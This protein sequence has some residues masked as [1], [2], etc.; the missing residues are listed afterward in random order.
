MKL[1]SK[2]NRQLLKEDNKKYIKLTIFILGLIFFVLT[3]IKISIIFSIIIL[4]ISLL[5][6]YRWLNKAEM[7]HF[8]FDFIMIYWF[9]VN[10]SFFT[11]YHIKVD[12]YFIP[13]L[14][15]FAYLFTLSL[16]LIFDKLKS[17]RH[18]EKIK[19]VTP[20]AIVCFLLLC[21]GVYSLTSSPHTYDNQMHPNFFTA[22]SE[23]KAVGDW[24]IKHDPEYMNK[25]VWAD[26]GGDFTFLLKSRVPSMEK[27]SEQNNFTDRMIKENV[28]YFIAK[29]NKTIGEPYVKLYQNGEVSLYYN[30]NENN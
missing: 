2:K 3:F 29:D 28:T 10:L 4:S 7:D 19:V 13:M 14:P 15:F 8:D 17:V 16:E 11:Y 6:L 18:I 23:E 1:F 30:S 22:A 24:L 25:T 20:I 12:R 9:V 21:T 26:R 27:I 5:A